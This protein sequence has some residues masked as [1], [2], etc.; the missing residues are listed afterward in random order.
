LIARLGA[1]AGQGLAVAAAALL[2]ALL[3]T[4]LLGVGARAF[5]HPLAWTE[6]AAQHLLV[7]TGFVGL[8]IAA[9]NGAHIR[10]EAVLSVLPAGAR[11]ALAIGLH[12]LVI[13]FAVLLLR[14]GPSLVERNWDVEWVSL[15]LPSALLYIPVPIAAF[16]LVLTSLAEIASL[17]RRERLP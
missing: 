15:P 2:V 6:E 1:T 14:E 12:A 7:W 9:R 4:V 11:T 5:A 8:V 16:G 17:L 3:L 13:V 10:I